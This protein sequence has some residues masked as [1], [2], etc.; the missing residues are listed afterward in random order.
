MSTSEDAAAHA[1]LEQ[2]PLFR[3]AFEES[4]AWMCELYAYGKQRHGASLRAPEQ[5]AI[6]FDPNYAAFH[7]IRK[8]RPGFYMDFYR[9]PDAYLGTIDDAGGLAMPLKLGRPGTSRIN[10]TNVAQLDAV[11]LL[12]DRAWRMKRDKLNR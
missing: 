5:S 12:M 4:K 9:A 6:T 11:N 1:E 10:V 2:H 8:T 3:R 7:N